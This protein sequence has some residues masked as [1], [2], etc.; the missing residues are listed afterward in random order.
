MAANSAL[1]LSNV[2]A[3]SD[4]GGDAAKREATK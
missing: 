1:N 3:S 2:T 4:F